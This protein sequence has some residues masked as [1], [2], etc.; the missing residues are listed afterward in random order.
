MENSLSAAARR[1]QDSVA[2]SSAAEG[3]ASEKEEEGEEE[4]FSVLDLASASARR[5]RERKRRLLAP[6]SPNCSPVRRPP[7]QDAPEAS[8]MIVKPKPTRRSSGKVQQGKSGGPD[9][10]VEGEAKV[11]SGPEKRAAYVS[12]DKIVLAKKRGKSA[13][14]ADTARAAEARRKKNK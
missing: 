3:G 8:S 12:V 11:S 14:K 9:A 5:R 2:L 13:G 10:R 7:L 6:V 1:V 4:E